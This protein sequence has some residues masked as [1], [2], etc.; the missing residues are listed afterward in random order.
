MSG[1]EVK[2]ATRE[3]LMEFEPVKAALDEAEAQLVDYRQTLEKRYG[4]ALKL[5][6]WSV[7]ALGFARLVVRPLPFG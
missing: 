1:E 7:V 3:E 5:R 6:A 2:A 4:V